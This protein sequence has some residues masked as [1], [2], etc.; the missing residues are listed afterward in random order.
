MADTVSKAQFIESIADK[1]GSSKAQA[2]AF[3]KAYHEEIT[4]I[5]AK[6]SSVT[7]VG[8]GTFSVSERAGRDGRNPKTGETI[9]IAASKSA[10]FKP[11]KGLKDAVNK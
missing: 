9:R 6:G 3:V 4:H 1:L 8:F 7:F 10:K 2:E 5:L 11:G